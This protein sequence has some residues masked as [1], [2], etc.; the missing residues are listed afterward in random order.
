MQ[1]QKKM[2]VTPVTSRKVGWLRVILPLRPHSGVRLFQGSVS[3]SPAPVSRQN[4]KQKRFVTHRAFSS[5]PATLIADCVRP[6][7]PGRW[8]CLAAPEVKD[9]SRRPGR[10]GLKN[11]S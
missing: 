8:I 9:K 6:R 2:K 11:V 3:R 7:L 10:Q 4:K 1:K 5:R